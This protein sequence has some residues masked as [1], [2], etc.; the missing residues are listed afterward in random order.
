MRGLLLR[1][2][3]VRCARAGSR[4]GSCGGVD[5]PRVVDA[6]HGLETAKASNDPIAIETAATAVEKAQAKRKKTSLRKRN[7]GRLATHM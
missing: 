5:D 6:E 4:G 1:A 7:A 3:F 2:C